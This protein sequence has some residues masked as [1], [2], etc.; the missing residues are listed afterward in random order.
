MRKLV[1]TLALGFVCSGFAG[2]R[3]AGRRHPPRPPAAPAASAPSPLPRPAAV[4]QRRGCRGRAAPAAAAPAPVPNKGDMAWMIVA[5]PAGHHDD[6]PGPGPVLRRPGAQQ[7]HAV[8][9]DAGVRHL[10][11]DRRAVV[12]VRL[13]PGLH[14]GQRLHW[15]LRPAVHEG[16]VRPDE[17]EFANGGHLQ[18]GRGDSR[19]AV[20]GLPGHLCR[21]HLLPDRRRL[22]R[23]H[24]V[25]G[26]AD[27]HGAVVHLQL[28]ADR[29]H[30][31]VLDGPGCLHRRRTWSTR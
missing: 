8:G 3:A 23:A 10:L 20:H 18:Q 19:A 27:V 31:V 14:R 5:T 28:P 29:P 30:G 22:R 6:D 21:H 12:P 11:D 25:L 24:Q 9:A 7:E 13:Q 17:G 1:A 16:H 2:R 15:R 26:R 4:R